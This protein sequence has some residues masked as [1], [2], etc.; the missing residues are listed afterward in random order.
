MIKVIFAMKGTARGG[1]ETATLTG[2]E[3]PGEWVINPDQ[4]TELDAWI[5]ECN[6]AASGGD[7]ALLELDDDTELWVPVSLA[8][9]LEAILQGVKDT[10]GARP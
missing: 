9:Y 10:F 1:V 6:T 5:A 8:A 4:G 3:L 7:P 2:P